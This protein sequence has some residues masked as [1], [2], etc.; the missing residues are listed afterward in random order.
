M[1]LINW[2]VALIQFI[3]AFNVYNKNHKA[4]VN[5]LFAISS[6]FMGIW[7]ILLFFYDHEL[8]LTAHTWL[9]LV[10]ISGYL[11]V[12][13]HILFSY[14]FPKKS[15]GNLKF[16]LIIYSLFSLIG[17]YLLLF[18]DTVI[19]E[20][21]H[22]PEL[23]IS[24]AKINWGYSIF[25]IPILLGFWWLSYLFNRKVKYLKGTER[26]QFKFYLI[27]SIIMAL[28]VFIV[29]LFLPIFLNETRYFG[30]SPIFTFIYV[31]TVTYAMI[32]HRFLGLNVIIG[33][34]VKF[35]L[36]LIIFGTLSYFSWK[37]TKYASQNLIII[38]LLW[39]SSVLI[40]NTITNKLKKII[41]DF[42][43]YSH[44]DPTKTLKVFTEN[45]S[46]ELNINKICITAL[47]ILKNSLNIEK[48]GLLIKNTN[49]TKTI[50]EKYIGFQ[51]YE[52]PKYIK[53]SNKNIII[54]KELKNNI[55]STK[56]NKR[57]ID[58]AEN[59]QIEIII[60]LKQ[61]L[62]FQGYLFLGE[63]L[64]KDVHTIKEVE[65]LQDFNIQ[66]SIALSRAILHNEVE[67]LNRNLQKRVEKATEELRKKKEEIE[68][69][70]RKER[71]MMDI[72]GHELRTPLAVA[73]NGLSLIKINFEKNNEEGKEKVLK[74]IEKSQEAIL[75]EI[76]IVN[77]VLSS[78]KITQDR[79]QLNLKAIKI[80]PIITSVIEAFQNKANSKGLKI[81]FDKSENL[82]PIYA[83]KT[84]YKQI[85]TNLISNAVK[86]TNQGEINIK[87]FEKEEKVCVAIKDSGVGIS[88]KDLE[89]LGK[90]FYRAKQYLNDKGEKKTKLVR[91]GGTGLGLYVSFGLADLMA[92]KIEVESKPGKGS[93]FTV[94]I[95]KYENQTSELSSDTE[96]KNVFE[97]RDLN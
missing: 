9:K 29:D 63:K 2:A 60:K 26:L 1:G 34:L 73:R 79:M 32:K 23:N 43:I 42:I 14:Y 10:L 47:S 3:L 40:Y 77:S 83:D 88:K 61:G 59:H 56:T 36:Q 55:S 90:K 87:T 71:D 67:N 28:G 41:N 53:T 51:L 54:P 68:E 22:N 76:N 97:R 45:T 94:C 8:L 11:M 91:P 13:F 62:N 24:I 80:T 72:L 30:V 16:V 31:G 18:T 19:T 52:I 33:G 85:I 66:L 37:L 25:Y 65:F 84:R 82:T 64:G 35:L 50:F 78:T 48:I 92:G 95:P 15:E 57:I 74:W 38:I 12:F 81:K 69:T 27:G 21:R 70:L 6:I 75:N 39:S 93:T 49:S 20:V 46:T 17:I 4:K 86:Y 5:K 89:N 7:A 44:F 96:S 58:W